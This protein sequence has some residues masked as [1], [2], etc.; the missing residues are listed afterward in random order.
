VP[1]NHKL[2]YENYELP[3]IQNYFLPKIQDWISQVSIWR[4]EVVDMIA[5]FSTEMPQNIINIFAKTEQVSISSMFYK[6]LLR[7]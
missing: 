5:S 4:T 6:Q 2:I 3:K 7:P 1:I